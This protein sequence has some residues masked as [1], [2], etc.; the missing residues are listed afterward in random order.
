M[1]D[2]YKEIYE[3]NQR[4]KFLEDGFKEIERT[5]VCIGKPLNDWNIKTPY[6]DEHLREYV[7]IYEVVKEMLR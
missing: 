5:L 6:Q 1:S 7:Q 2:I 4:I 3:L